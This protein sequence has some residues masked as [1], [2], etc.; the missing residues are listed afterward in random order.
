VKRDSESGGD[1]LQRVE[2]RLALPAFEHGHKTC[3]DRDS[4]CE[5]ALGNVGESPRNSDCFRVVH[6]DPRILGCEFSLELEH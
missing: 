6:C 3:I 4:F 2:A 5:L 1:L